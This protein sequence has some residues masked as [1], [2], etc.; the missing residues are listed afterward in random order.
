[1]HNLKCFLKSL[2][3]FFKTGKYWRHDYEGEYEAE[4]VIVVYDGKTV[5]ETDSYAHGLHEVV[6]EALKIKMT[7]KNCGYEAIGYI[8][9]NGGKVE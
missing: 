9:K 2:L 8:G 4:D 6:T 3:R 7:C 5:R 1:M